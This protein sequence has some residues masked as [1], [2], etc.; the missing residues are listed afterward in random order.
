MFQTATQLDWKS[1]VS[2]HVD[3]NMQTLMEVSRCVAPS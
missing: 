3:I 1:V 2:G